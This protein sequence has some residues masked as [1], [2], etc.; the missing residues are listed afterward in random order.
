MELIFHASAARIHCP[1]S[2]TTFWWSNRLLTNNNFIQKVERQKKQFIILLS[3]DTRDDEQSENVWK[4]FTN[5][6]IN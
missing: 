3:F 6:V 1:S 4:A 2:D 5:K